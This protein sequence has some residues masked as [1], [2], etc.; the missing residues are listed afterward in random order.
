MAAAAALFS[1][2][3]LAERLEAGD[4]GDYKPNAIDF[5]MFFEAGPRDSP[6]CALTIRDG[7]A[8]FGPTVTNPAITCPDAFAWKVFAEICR[9]KSYSKPQVTPQHS[10]LIT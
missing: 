1:F 6:E 3:V 10:N 4:D 5:S 2:C 9:W 7:R 8:D